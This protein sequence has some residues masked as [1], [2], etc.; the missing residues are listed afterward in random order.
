MFSSLFLSC[1]QSN[2]FLQRSKY[3]LGWFM[4][5][6]LVKSPSLTYIWRKKIFNKYFAHLHQPN[7]IIKTFDS[8]CKH[9]V[10]NFK[11]I[12]WKGVRTIQRVVNVIWKVFCNSSKRDQQNWMIFS[13]SSSSS[14]FKN[15]RHCHHDWKKFCASGNNLYDRFSHLLCIR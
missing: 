8:T 4:S 7:F 5:L 11:M 14:K 12:S 3:K 15:Q 1:R 6:L 10:C 2:G 9:H 13:S